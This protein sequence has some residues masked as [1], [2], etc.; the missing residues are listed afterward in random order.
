MYDLLLGKFASDCLY[1]NYCLCW[2]LWC[3]IRMQLLWY[4]FVPQSVKCYII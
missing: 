2:K 1:V 4:R 3:L